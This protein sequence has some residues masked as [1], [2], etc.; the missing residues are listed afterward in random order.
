MPLFSVQSDF[1]SN[2]REVVLG[3]AWYRPEQWSLLRA[4]AADPDKL[5][6]TH[7]EWLT[8][9]TKAVGDLQKTGVGVKKIDV[10]VQE[11]ARWCQDRGL[12]LD[13]SA[14]AT[15]VTEKM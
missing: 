11:L 7:A 15:F 8:V 1:M 9:A 10:D 12:A 2:Q 3:F 4:L 6:Q 5:E 14:R 13:G